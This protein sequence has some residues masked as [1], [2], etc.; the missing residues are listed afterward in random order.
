[1]VTFCSTT[2]CISNY[3]NNRPVNGSVIFRGRSISVYR[4]SI[5][6]LTRDIYY[7]AVFLAYIADDIFIDGC[8]VIARLETDYQLKTVLCE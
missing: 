8:A 4:R 6:C 7:C 1:M 2:D 3:V 5:F